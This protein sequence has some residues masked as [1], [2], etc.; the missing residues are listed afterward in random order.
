VFGQLVNLEAARLG[1][2]VVALVTR[3]FDT[4]VHGALVFFQI[5]LFTGNVEAPVARE[6]HKIFRMTVF[7]VSLEPHG[8][9]RDVT[10]LVAVK[11]HTAV[12]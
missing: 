7:L 8:R 10:A 9:G 6:P 11:V 2:L 4:I 3:I 1:G 5:T 12:S